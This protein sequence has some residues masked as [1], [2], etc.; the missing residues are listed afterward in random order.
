MA[1][2]NH[3]HQ[4]LVVPTYCYFIMLSKL[5]VYK[6]TAHPTL[7]QTGHQVFSPL[8]N[9]ANTVHRQYFY[10]LYGVDYEDEMKVAMN[11]HTHTKDYV[12]INKRKLKTRRFAHLTVCKLYDTEFAGR[13]PIGMSDLD[14]LG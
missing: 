10:V 4:L 8:K 7:K 11:E 14:F 13:H 6:I 3:D 2:S 5:Q 1:S 12:V 9:N